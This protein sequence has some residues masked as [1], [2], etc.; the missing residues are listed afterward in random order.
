MA[1]P[2]QAFALRYIDLGRVERNVQFAEFWAVNNKGYE[3][4]CSDLRMIVMIA[5]RI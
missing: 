2:G 3:S 1:A 5:N 4:R